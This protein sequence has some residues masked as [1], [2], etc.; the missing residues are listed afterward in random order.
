M[1]YTELQNGDDD[2]DCE[3]F[4]GI[5]TSDHGFIVLRLGKEAQVEI[6]ANI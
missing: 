3:N 2:N 6:L 5:A 1:T 4:M